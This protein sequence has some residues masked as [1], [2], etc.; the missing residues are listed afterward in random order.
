MTDYS[1]IENLSNNSII[2]LYNDVVTDEMH[3]AVSSRCTAYCKCR[4]GSEG[5]IDFTWPYNIGHWVYGGVTFPVYQRV[6]YTT[7]SC[8]GACC[9]SGG[10]CKS[11]A[12]YYSNVAYNCWLVN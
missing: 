6:D 12:N 3:L 10:V 11:K 5:Y 9:E 2:E 1:E 4:D 7:N 8:F